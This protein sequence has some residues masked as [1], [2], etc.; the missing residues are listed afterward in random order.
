MTNIPL[1]CTLLA[2]PIC[3]RAPPL[4]PV[5][6]DT[7]RCLLWLHQACFAAFP[8]VQTTHHGIVLVYPFVTDNFRAFV[9]LVETRNYDIPTF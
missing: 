7:R 1:D 9:R 8:Y 5:S 2:E 4:L 3:E 6:I